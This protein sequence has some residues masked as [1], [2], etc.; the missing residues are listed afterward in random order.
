[1]STKCFQLVVSLEHKVLSH[2]HKVLSHEHK[3]LP[4][5]KTYIYKLY[6]L[7]K[8][9]SA[10]EKPPSTRTKTTVV[11]HAKASHQDHEDHAHEGPE[12]DDHQAH[13]DHAHEGPE[14][15]EV[16]ANEGHAH[17]EPQGHEDPADEGHENHEGP[18]HED[19]TQERR[20]THGCAMEWA[21]P[22]RQCWMQ[23]LDL[24]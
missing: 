12:E 22:V 15:Q 16:Q 13:E 14:G 24:R 19:P 4:Y 2:E 9:S 23:E 1:M 6:I 21:H 20:P 18:S 11:S 10:Q 5:P 17:D 3:V 7:F 8:P